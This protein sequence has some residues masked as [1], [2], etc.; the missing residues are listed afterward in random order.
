M[1]RK[2]IIVGR[3]KLKE[4][5]GY[6]GEKEKQESIH[7]L[8][9]CEGLRESEESREEVLNENGRG[10]AK[11]W[12][13]LSNNS[14]QLNK[15]NEVR[16]ETFKNYKERLDLHFQVKGYLTKLLEDH[17][18]PKKNPLVKQHKFLSI[19]HQENESIAEYLGTLRQGIADCNSVCDCGKSIADTFLRA[20][21]IRGI[22]D[23]SMRQQ[24]LQNS[25]LTFDEIIN[26][27]LTYEASKIAS[28]EISTQNLSTATSI[29]KV[30]TKSSNH[31]SS[32]RSCNDNH[33]NN[34]KYRYRSK[35]KINYRHLGTNNLCLRCG[36]NN[37]LAKE[38][39]INPNNLKCQS[40]NR[41]GHVQRISIQSLL[42][43]KSKK[44]VQAIQ[45]TDN[46][47]ETEYYSNQDLHSINEVVDI[48][49]NN[50]TDAQK[51]FTDV[52]IDGKIQTFEVD[53]GAGY[54]LLPEADFHRLHLNI[55]LKISRTGF[56]SYTGEIFASSGTVNVI[57]EYQVRKSNEEMYIVSSKYSPLLGRRWIRHLG[58]NLQDLDNTKIFSSKTDHPVPN[59]ESTYEIISKYSEIFQPIVGCIPN[60]TCS[61]KLREKSKPTFL[62]ERQVPYTLQEAVKKELDNL[63]GDNIITGVDTSG[64]GS[65]LVVI[66]KPDGTVRLC[67][68]YKIAVNPQL[69][70][71]HYPIRRIDNILNNLK[72]S[73][74]FCRLDL[75]K[76][77]LHVKVEEE[78]RAIQTISAHRGIYQMNRPFFGIKTAPSEFNR[79]LD[80]ILQGLEGTLSY[81]DDIII[82][83]S[84]LEDC[85]KRLIN[86]FERLKTYN[87]QI[88]RGKC[89]FFKKEIQYLGII[90]SYNQ[91]SNIPSKHSCDLDLTGTY[92]QKNNKYI[93]SLCLNDIPGT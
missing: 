57:V 37:H 81:F 88:N 14:K 70:S 49:K 23:N 54:T 71:A 15:N 62:K 76:A 93:A 6:F 40:C 67:V 10:L 87:L 65:P 24:L 12:Q 50:Q 4:G 25:K 52:Y 72:D 32:G 47:I 84:S 46:S 78:S 92:S 77:Y 27:V 91:I 58:I 35:S 20:Q 1:K 41:T 66:P 68:D 48:Y 36:R 38:C 86:C 5:V 16:K 64:W 61:L 79:I 89:D 22:C 13:Q 42:K 8:E 56:R 39:R 26:K 3:M 33:S 82:H 28:N 63:E 2:R 60:V 43:Q 45:D 31:C 90:I 11:A 21:F 59:L 9:E 73:A 83:G 30:S 34:S 85:K 18:C 80:Q 19:Y 17:F 55:P 69:T 53:S 7:I 75:S 74:Y 29:N 44:N 51:Y